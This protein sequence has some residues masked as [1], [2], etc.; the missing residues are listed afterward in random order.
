MN[1]RTVAAFAGAFALCAG[2]AHAAVVSTFTPFTGDPAEV[3][4]TIEDSGDG[5]QIS[6]AVDSTNTGNVADIRGFFFDLAGFD[7]G[8]DYYFTGSDISGYA[9]S[10]GGISNLGGGNNINGGGSPGPLDFGVDIGSPG[11]G[12]DDVQSTSFFFG[13]VGGTVSETAF[14]G[15]SGAVRVTSVGP[16]GGSRSG[17]SKTT[18]TFEEM[19]PV[20][21]PASGL[22]LLGGF[23]AIAALRRKEKVV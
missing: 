16:D 8:L 14:I 7:A 15:Q 2:V 11:I 5:V 12:S 17:S 6:L 23:G 10:A 19:T 9:Y 3:Q 20:P 21:L 22:L 1:K 13:V 18:G 4:V